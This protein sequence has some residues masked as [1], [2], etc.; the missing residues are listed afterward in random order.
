LS[1][2]LVFS[3]VFILLQH[4][5]KR[6]HMSDPIKYIISVVVAYLLGSIPVGVFVVRLFGGRDIRTV[7]SGRTGGTNALRAAGL[8]AGVVTGLGDVAKGYAAIAV[9]RLVAGTSLP[10]LEALC[11]VAVVS[12]HNW[13][14]YI[15][16]K[17]GAGTGPNVGAA[18]AFWPWTGA[19]LIPLVPIVLLTTG[20][21]SLA[22][23]SAS[24]IIVAIFIIRAIFFNQ[25]T[26]YIGYAIA[27]TILT[28][29]ALIPNYKRLVAGT[30]RRV[31]PRARSDAPPSREAPPS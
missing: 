19:I 6:I 26:A 11:A 9:A 8:P 27:T 31:G 28:A 25:P 17:G 21:A 13:P 4:S 5:S 14:I 20:Y 16:F 10:I 15:N 30:E 29:I 18:T 2:I 12:G 24:L 3:E 1:H 7:G 22:S 23:T